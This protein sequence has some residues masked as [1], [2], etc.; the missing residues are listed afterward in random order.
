MDHQWRLRAGKHP[1]ARLQAGFIAGGAFSFHRIQD[2][3][4]RP[5][6]TAA[7]FKS[8]LRVEEQALIDSHKD[9]PDL[10]NRSTN[11]KGPDSDIA[12]QRW[13]NPEYRERVVAGMKNAPPP[14]DEARSKMA[15]AKKGD[16]NPKSRAVIVTCPDGTTKRYGSTREAA[17]FF[18]VTQQCMDQWM[19]GITAWPGTGRITRGKNKWIASYRAAFEDDNPSARRTLTTVG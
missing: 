10:C 2:M 7:E 13:K 16:L 19:K 15:A 5:N 4:R 11:A 18:K 9:H 17:S 1:V 8:R 12:K 6:E 3:A 14:S